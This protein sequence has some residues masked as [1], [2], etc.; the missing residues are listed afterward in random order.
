MSSA[1]G[2]IVKL[3]LLTGVRR[4]ENAGVREVELDLSAAEPVLTIHSGRAKNRNAHRVPLS[5]QAAELFRDAIAKA[6]TSEFV[7]PSERTATHIAPESVSQAMERTRAKLGIEDV[8]MHDLRR[9]VGTYMSRLG[10]PKDI[11]ERILN[12]GGKRKGSITE[13]VYN[14][15]EYNPEKR[16]ALE[17]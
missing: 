5:R 15:Y 6:G 12:H 13:G 11:R 17:L 2:T 9:T 1:V 3:A 7:F 10:V 8:A 14:R 4:S 16:A